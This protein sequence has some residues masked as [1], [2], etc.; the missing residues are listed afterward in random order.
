MLLCFQMVAIDC[1]NGSSNIYLFSYCTT[2][3]VRKFKN[4]I[5]SSNVIDAINCGCPHFI[6]ITRALL[7]GWNSFVTWSTG[8]RTVLLKK[9]CDHIVKEKINNF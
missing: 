6:A 9:Q 2:T 7:Y 8:I 4:Q 3:N 1:D 5:R